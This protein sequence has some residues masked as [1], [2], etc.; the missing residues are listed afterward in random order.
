MWEEMKV[1][2]VRVTHQAHSL[3]KVGPQSPYHANPGH[4]FKSQLCGTAGPQGVYPD[5][6][7]E[8]VQRAKG[9]PF[10]Q[11]VQAS[12]P[13]AELGKGWGGPTSY[14]SLSWLY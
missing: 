3:F 12:F 11:V 10:S 7:S 6:T 9:T 4:K 14:P 13:A 2:D 1:K 5:A 8:K